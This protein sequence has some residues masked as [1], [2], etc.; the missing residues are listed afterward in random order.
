[1]KSC[2][3]IDEAGF[4]LHIKRNVGRSKKGTPAKTTVPT[5]RGITITIIGAMCEKG[6]VS[7]ALRKPSVVVSKKKRKLDINCTTVEVNGRIGTR[8]SHYLN[9]LS[10]T[11]DAL[12]ANGMKGRYLVMDNPLL[13]LCKPN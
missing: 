4:N 1:M 5:R 11:M 3:F 7:L 6:I 9:Y 12:D 8:T 2:V 13:A 10:S